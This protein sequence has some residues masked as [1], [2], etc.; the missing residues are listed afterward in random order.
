MSWHSGWKLS[1]VRFL[2]MNGRNSK[3]SCGELCCQL[4]CVVMCLVSQ[5]R[6]PCL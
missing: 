4:Q 6:I 3:F 5:T 1:G 2:K